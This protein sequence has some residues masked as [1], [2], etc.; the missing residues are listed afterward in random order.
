[1]GTAGRGVRA[2]RFLVQSGLSPPAPFRADAVSWAAKWWQEEHADG[3]LVGGD[4][5]VRARTCIADHYGYRG[6][7]APALLDV[8]TV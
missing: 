5:K 3:P 6:D 4:G 1:M 7:C 2:D 8:R